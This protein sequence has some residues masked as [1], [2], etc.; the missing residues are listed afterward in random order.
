MSIFA[1]FINKAIQIGTHNRMEQIKKARFLL[2][3]KNSKYFFATLILVF[4]TIT[5]QAQTNPHKGYIITNDG[6]TIQGTID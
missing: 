1:V 6:D 5:G 3:L 2:V 4:M